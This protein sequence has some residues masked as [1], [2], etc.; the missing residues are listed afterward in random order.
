MLSFGIMKLL[1]EHVRKSIYWT[2]N[3]E[4]PLSIRKLQKYE[5]ITHNC[6][7]DTVTQFEENRF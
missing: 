1:S 3:Q 4:H 2:M 7:Y 5:I 6:L